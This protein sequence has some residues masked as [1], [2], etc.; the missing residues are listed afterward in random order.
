M[1]Y[2]VLNFFNLRFYCGFIWFHWKF[3]TL[4]SELQT[5]T[6][7]LSLGE[8]MHYYCTNR[9]NVAFRFVFLQ[10]LLP[11]LIN[12]SLSVCVCECVQFPLFPPST[13]WWPLWCDASPPLK[14]IAQTIRTHTHT[15]VCESRVRIFGTMAHQWECE[16]DGETLD[17]F[18]RS[19]LRVCVC[20]ERAV[21][22]AFRFCVCV[23]REESFALQL[24]GAIHSNLVSFEIKKINK[25]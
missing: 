12:A 10:F 16:C 21:V 5:K 9:M 13:K 19:F 24:L 8:L 1:G 25:K 2:R 17:R 3:F 23:C 18:F 11:C 22:F 14:L 15:C 20:E 7:L 4:V 6:K